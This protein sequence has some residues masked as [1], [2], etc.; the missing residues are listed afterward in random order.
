MPRVLVTLLAL[1]LAPAAAGMAGC[2]RRQAVLRDEGPTRVFN[3]EHVP[4]GYVSASAYS[5]YVEAQL[6]SLDGQHEAAAQSMT[7]A[8]A[9]DGSSAY[10]RTRLGEELLSLGR[11]DEARDAFE[12][13]LRFDPDFADAWVGLGRIALGLGD[14]AAAERSFRRALELD[15]TCEEAWLQLAS[16]YH[17]RGEGGRADDVYKSMAGRLP[18]SAAA[19]QQV[20]RS[21]VLRGD[22]TGATTELRRAVELMPGNLDARLDLARVLAATDEVEPAERELKIAWERSGR[23]PR[24]GELLIPLLAATGK[25]EES[26]TLLE[27][28]AA[29]AG[30]NERRLATGAMMIARHRSARARTLAEAALSSTPKPPEATA[31]Q[32]LLARVLVEEN[33]F[34]E[35]A[36]RLRSTIDQIG[37]TGAG[38][39]TA[40]VAVLLANVLEVQGSRAEARR[41][42]ESVPAPSEAVTLALAGVLER[43]GEIDRA[44]ELVQKLLERNPASAEAMTFLALRLIDRGARPRDAEKLL[45]VARALRPPT[46]EILDAIGSLHLRQDRIEPALALLE[47]AARLLPESPVVLKHLGDAYAR[48]KDRTRAVAAY[49]RALSHNPDAKIQKAVEERLLHW[50]E[51]RVGAR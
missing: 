30:S 43:G 20:A 8:I 37:K 42:L 31:A 35:A 11:V 7:R 33:K 21:A 3:G 29:A 46:G 16:L 6:L 27:Q 36:S 10:L 34:D 45:I 50:E 25:M 32:L 41:T 23:D 40:D 47:Q 14:V 28:Q 18:E 44:V 2:A 15:R 13:A 26:D 38:P 49:R 4:G 9:S 22:L 39:G 1:S 17:D 51:G 48:A 12:V 24:V 5:H 19:H